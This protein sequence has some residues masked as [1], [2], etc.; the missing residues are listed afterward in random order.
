MRRK[1][2]LSSP[3]IREDWSVV[4]KYIPFKTRFSKV[5][6]PN[7]R[8]PPNESKRVTRRLFRRIYPKLG[9]FLLKSCFIEDFL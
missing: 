5:K 1:N 7:V 2:V 8:T 9:G 6:P 4:P 3:K